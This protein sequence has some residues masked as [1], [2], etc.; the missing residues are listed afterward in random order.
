ME[1]QI[2]DKLKQQLGIRGFKKIMKDKIRTLP[3][4]LVSNLTAHNF[5]SSIKTSV[6]PNS[7]DRN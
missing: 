3:M 6:L 7:S 5:V 4:N 1:S 2:F